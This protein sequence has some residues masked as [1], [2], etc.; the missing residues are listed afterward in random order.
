ML[1]RLT[2]LVLCIAVAVAVAGM[3]CTATRAPRP[4]TAPEAWKP[5]ADPARRAV[6]PPKRPPPALGLTRQIAQWAEGLE[7]LGTLPGA[8]AAAPGVQM[9]VADSPLGAWV[10]T[11]AHAGAGLRWDAGA[12]QASVGLGSEMSAQS[13]QFGAQQRFRGTWLH[14]GALR[15]G[16]QA[17]A[18][19]ASA[20]M[21]LDQG[22]GPL[23]YRVVLRAASPAGTA[24]LAPTPGVDVLGRMWLPGGAQLRSAWNS[25][26]VPGQPGT[27]RLDLSLGD[28][29][30]APSWARGFGA[31]CERGARAGC[32]LDLRFS[33]D[34]WDVRVAPQVGTA[35]LADDAALESALVVELI[36]ALQRVELRWTDEDHGAP[37]LGYRVEI[38]LR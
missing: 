21:T 6:A 33:H 23:D 10:R 25:A 19:G 12:R 29:A 8:T 3:A 15:S 31:H 26:A 20:R 24:D 4:F 28:A 32:G 22:L 7:P 35:T 30:L 5:A 16:V 36:G 11:D 2:P 18:A 1:F 9:G 27:G 38:P 37:A 34:G 14:D 13:L 17:D